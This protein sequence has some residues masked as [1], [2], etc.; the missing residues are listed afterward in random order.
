MTATFAQAQAQ[1]LPFRLSKYL[2]ELGCDEAH[3]NPPVVDSFAPRI[4]FLS[5]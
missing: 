5:E 3:S 4:A 1:L 2:A